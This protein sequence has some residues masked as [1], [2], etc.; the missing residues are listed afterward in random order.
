MQNAN[1]LRRAVAIAGVIVSLGGALWTHHSR[2]ERGSGGPANR[3]VLAA[4]QFLS[5]P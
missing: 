2:P 5:P 1:A 3:A 4:L